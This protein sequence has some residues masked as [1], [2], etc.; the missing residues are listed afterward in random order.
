M[1]TITFVVTFQ[2]TIEVDETQYG[3]LTD[4]EIL[5][6]QGFTKLAEHKYEIV[7]IDGWED[8]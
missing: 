7:E 3:D 2:G 1:K 4:T 8:A 6:E 5:A